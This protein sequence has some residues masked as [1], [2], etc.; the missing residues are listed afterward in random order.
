MDFLQKLSPQLIETR[1]SRFSGRLEVYR[2]QDKYFIKTGDVHQ[3]GGWAERLYHDVNFKFQFLNF[4]LKNVLM[5]GLAGGT[6]VE[7]L[8]KMYPNINITGVDIDPVM[9]N[10]GKKYFNLNKYKNLKIEIADAFEYVKRVNKQFDLVIIDLFIRDQ[11]QVESGDN[12]FLNNILLVT[13]PHGYIMINRLYLPE[14]KKETDA[15]LNFLKSEER[16]GEFKIKDIFQNFG[17]KVIL[18]RKE[19]KIENEN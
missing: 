4:K 14:F 1:E 18:L 12:N 19:G 9:V 2:F 3:S 17:N 5:L 16:G 10:L 8:Y 11:V 7:L 13:R 6:L 15:Y